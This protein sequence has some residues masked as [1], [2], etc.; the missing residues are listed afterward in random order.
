MLTIFSMKIDIFENFAFSNKKKIYIKKPYDA[1]FLIIIYF[2]P[3]IVYY[4]VSDS[5]VILWNP[6]E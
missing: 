6:S 2:L 1:L 5:S 3:I 4:T